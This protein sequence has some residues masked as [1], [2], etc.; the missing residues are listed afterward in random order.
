MAKYQGL[1]SSY[2]LTIDQVKKVFLAQAS[3]FFSV[4]DGQS[5]IKDYDNLTQ[6]LPANTFTLIIDAPELKPSTP[7]VAAALEILLKKYIEVPFKQRFFVSK[8]NLFTV[9][10]FKRLGGTI[11]GWT[12][13]VQYVDE[14]EDAMKKL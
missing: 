14:L 12:D 10:Q 5:F 3:G 2:E 13:G 6:S 1:K 8:G 4:E 7:E 9:M 11:A